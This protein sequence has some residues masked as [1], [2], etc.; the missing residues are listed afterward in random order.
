[1][2]D[3]SLP[4]YALT[5]TIV[6]L[7]MLAVVV[8]GGTRPAWVWILLIWVSVV[9]SGM[10][11]RGYT[12]VDELLTA[13]L[14]I[15]ALIHL[16][17]RGEPRTSRPV[18][19]L[20]RFHQLGFGALMAYLVVQSARGVL[21]LHSPQKVRW[22]VFYA[23]L[24]VLA[25]ILKNRRFIVPSRREAALAVTVSTAVYLTLFLLAGV[26]AELVGLTTWF[27]FGE[28]RWAIQTTWWGSTAY[29]ILPVG[30]AMPAVVACLRDESKPWRRAGWTTLLLA[31]A[32]ALYY[33][34]R[35]GVLAILTCLLVALPVL[36]VRRVLGVAFGAT[37]VLWLFLAFLWSGRR[38]IAF[39]A[40]DLF[41]SGT[42][43]WRR[44]AE[45]GAARDV[46]RWIHMQVAFSSIDGDWK[47]RWF[48]HGF[49][50]S[51]RVISSSVLALYQQ[52]MPERAE[53]VRE[54]ESTEAFTA[55][56][57]DTGL[58]GLL[59]LVL[60]FVLVAAQVLRAKACAERYVVMTSLVFLFLW[61]FVINLLDVTL[62]YLALM[63]S[64]LLLLLARAT[65]RA[66][67]PAPARLAATPATGP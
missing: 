25:L 66:G 49:R 3:P 2:P 18:D 14:V 58:I 8:V 7:L 56:V 4:V 61:L 65:D 13:A 50:T 55:L 26:V 30:I 36:G 28:G 31:V 1:M 62:Y 16:A 11:P 44:D 35:I 48:G 46:D 6:L 15:G 12:I 23:M 39:V 41:G 63:P 51:G 27:E 24:G 53:R 64:G 5:L 60:N 9:A 20:C 17:L 37:A 67:P 22:I 34:S 32:T 45:P 52:Y 21:V 10:M 40:A 42:A 43:V 47:T 59:L 54:D 57:V 29:A 38:D 33:D 19:W